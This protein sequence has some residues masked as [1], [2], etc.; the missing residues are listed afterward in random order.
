MAARQ[1]SPAAVGAILAGVLS[2]A[3]VAYMGFT[4]LKTK[5]AD[6]PEVTHKYDT[7]I[8]S[9]E[10]NSENEKSVFVLSVSLFTPTS[11]TSGGVPYSPSELGKTDITQVG[12]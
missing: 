5:P 9:T 8:L 1:L 7:Q 10:L 12:Q 6:V 2:V 3:V 11:L 4:F